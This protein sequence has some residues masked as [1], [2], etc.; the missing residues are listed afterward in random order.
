MR[1][2]L[3]QEQVVDMLRKMIETRT[4]SSLAEEIGISRSFFCEVVKGTRPPT[5]KILQFL[6]LDCHVV[7]AR[8]GKGG[9]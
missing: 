2:Y 7:Y 6:G 1:E 5:G 3:E 9:A 4:Q 8:S